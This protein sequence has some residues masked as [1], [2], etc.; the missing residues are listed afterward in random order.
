ME[1]LSSALEQMKFVR[2]FNLLDQKLGKLQNW[3]LT[4][5]LNDIRNTYTM[6]LRFMVKGVRD[7]ESPRLMNEL[8]RRLYSVSD[9][10]GRFERLKS[11]H[12]DRYSQVQHSEHMPIENVASTLEV[13]WSEIN[14]LRSDSNER[15]SKR[16]YAE[17]KL[18]A[19]HE[20]AVVCMFDSIWTSDLWRKS[21]YD[22]VDG[23]I[24]S[25]I[26]ASFDKAVLV[27]AVT[28]SLLEMFDERKLMLLF[29]AYLC[30]DVEVSQRAIVGIILVMRKYDKRIQHYPEIKSRFELYAEGESF[31]K[32]FFVVMMQLQFSKMTD[33][34]SD[35]MRTDII[36]TIMKSKNFRKNGLGF[37]EL[38]AEEFKNGENPEWFGGNEGDEASAKLK[39][40]ADLQLEGADVYMGTFAYMKSYPFFAKMS[41]WFYP[42]SFD[43]P[44]MAEAKKLLAGKSSVIVK[45]MLGASPFCNSDKYSFCLMIKTVGDA[46]EQMLSQQM[47]KEAGESLDALV[48]DAANR[49]LKPADVSR[50]Y[51][52]D[53]YRFFKVY[54]YKREFAD[55]FS[56]SEPSF[57]P[58]HT[59]S[60][61]FISNHRTELLA[62]GEFFMRKECYCDAMNVF[63]SLSPN[64]VEEDAHL[65]QKIGFCQQKQEDNIGALRSYI[66]AD[67]FQPGSKWTMKHLASVAFK[68]ENFDTAERYYDMLLASDSDNVRLLQM[69]A[70]C[71]F[72]MRRYAEAVPILYKFDYLSDKSVT[73]QYMLALALLLNGD[74]DKSAD[75]LVSCYADN[76]DAAN[77]A[78]LLAHVRFIQG[79]VADAYALYRQYYGGDGSFADLFWDKVSLFEEVLGA[80]RC[81]FNLVYDAVCC[82]ALDE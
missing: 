49:K 7:P 23:I 16:E 72:E 25:E 21:D 30:N 11:Q 22:V 51:I 54:T 61:D 77:V 27:S 24:Q 8:L 39:E 52:Y 10:A 67:S 78:M 5:E 41:H 29:D 42:F 55:L 4:E 81:N 31:V 70:R 59:D 53:L 46:A 56:S 32:N 37:T 58:L 60:F 34:V 79:R 19:M 3:T 44:E 14:A 9:R 36:P 75:V 82:G 43:V 35:K 12:S 69:K 45:T 62:L 26:I 71:L 28:L 74:A 1:Q 15:P 13:Y 57:S 80:D 40:M 65:W 6:M 18:V 20:N 17:D 63:Q 48:E 50:F 68:T 76:P 33:K 38:D 2:I 73:S 47:E 64:E 66:V